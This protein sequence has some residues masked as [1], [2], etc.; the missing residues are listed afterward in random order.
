MLVQRR[1]FLRAVNF[2]VGRNNTKVSHLILHCTRT[3]GLIRTVDICMDRAEQRSYHFVIGRKGEIIQTVRTTD[4]AWHAGSSSVPDMNN[5][6]IGIALVGAGNHYTAKQYN[7]LYELS[8]LILDL[9][10]IEEKNIIGNEK[11]SQSKNIISPGPNFNWAFILDKLFP[12]SNHTHI[13]DSYYTNKGV[14]IP[15]LRNSLDKNI[16]GSGIQ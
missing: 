14:H 3:T 5:K 7:A 13:L 8:D 12:F 1:K 6:S 9:F 2:T 10:S 4:T 15:I 16:Y 11:I